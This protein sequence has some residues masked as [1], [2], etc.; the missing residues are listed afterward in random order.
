[1]PE[2]TPNLGI[3]KPLG[4]EYFNRSNFNQ[5]LDVI[6][7]KSTKKESFDEH[8]TAGNAHGI[9]DKSTLL[10]SNKTSIVGALNELFTNANDGKTAVA[11]AVTAKG[12]SASPA[13]TFSALAT[14]IGQINTGKKWAKGSVPL[15]TIPS[16]DYV[17][18]NSLGFT[19]KSAIV[20]VSYSYGET[21]MLI[22]YSTEFTEMSGCGI[23]YSGQSTGASPLIALGF[24]TNSLIL[25]DNISGFARPW[26]NATID[27]ICLE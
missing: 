13:D 4:N 24:S 7:N 17:L 12:V 18:S 9:G 11:N 6:D 25:L 3:P 8:T 22:T 19:P 2:N 23:T 27:W 21:K 1:V 14:K 16:G 5:I 15:S 26:S 20:R 10:T